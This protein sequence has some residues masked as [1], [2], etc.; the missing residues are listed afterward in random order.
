VGAQT[1]RNV[2]W[3]VHDL[4][5]GASSLCVLPNGPRLGPRRSATAQSLLRRNL[6]LASR[7]GP[8]RGDEI[9]GMYWGR[10]AIQAALDDVE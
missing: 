8:C 2:G 10:Q 9:L 4:A 6:N 7:E 5:A 3:T 1:A